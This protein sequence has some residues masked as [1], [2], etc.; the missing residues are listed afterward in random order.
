MTHD[1]QDS[2]SVWRRWDLHVHTPESKLENQFKDWA[3][4]LNKI[5]SWGRTVSVIG[6]TDYASIEGYKRLKSEIKNNKRLPDIDL[7]IPNIEFRISA[8]TKQGKGINVHLLVSPHETD[9]IERIESAL[10]KLCC[11]FGGEEYGCTRL[12]LIKLGKNVKPSIV[13]EELA[14][15]EG[16]NQFKPSI[17]EISKW[18][19][20]S[21]WLK[22]NSLVAVSNSS[23]DGV[24]GLNHD[25]G[26][27][28][29]RDEI[30]S[31]ADLV[32]SAN[33]KDREFY[34]GGG[35]LSAHQI[36]KK[37]RHLKPCVHGSDAHS[38]EKIFAPDLDRFCWIKADP[39]FEG[40]RQIIYE[41]DSRVY[42]GKQ[43][44][45]AHDQSKVIEQISISG[46]EGWFATQSIK[47]NSGLNAIIGGKGSGKTALADTIA[48]ACGAWEETS[49]SF[50]TRAKSE[51][52]NQLS[53]KIGW[54]DG[55]LVD[56]KFP[57]S[58]SIAKPLVKYLSQQF[59]E[60]LCT[61][62]LEGTELVHEIEKV[63]FSHLDEAERLG[64][65]SFTELRTLRVNSIRDHRSTLR[66]KIS[67]A[68]DRFT[69][70]EDE[71][72]QR[73]D[74]FQQRQ[75]LLGEIKTLE[76]Q[77]PPSADD[78][79]TEI[80]KLLIEARKQEESIE[81]TLA[82]FGRQLNEI[83]NVRYSFKQ[84]V[85]ASLE[86]F[87]DMESDLKAIG[88]TPAQIQLFQP[89]WSVSDV[90]SAL[91]ERESNITNSKTDL[92]GKETDVWPDN[93][94][95]T[96]I[97]SL[98]SKLDKQSNE[99]KAIKEKRRAIAISI[100]E[101]RAKT[102]KL[103]AEISRIDNEYVKRLEEVRGERK[104]LFRELFETLKKEQEILRLLY[105]PLS[106]KLA[107]SGDHEK[108]LE[109]FVKANVQFQEWADKGERLLDRTKIGAFRGKGALQEHL[110]EHFEPSLR[111]CDAEG[112]LT[113]IDALIEAMHDDQGT[114]T[115]DSQLRDKTPSRADWY[116][117]LFDTRQIGL[118]YGIRYDGVALEALS[119]GTKG[120]VLMILYLSMDQDEMA[121]LIIDQPE[122]NLD[123]ESIYSVLTPYFRLAKKRRQ[124]I[125]ITHNPNLVVNADAELIVVANHT[126]NPD[127][128]APRLRYKSGS[129]ENSR[130]KVPGCI[131]I[132]EC[133][134]DILEGGEKAF[135]ER[136]KRYSFKH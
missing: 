111:S 119:P 12:D 26:F 22:R 71:I 11:T 35:A 52:K 29:V 59:V 105:T 124:I 68:N 79:E 18:L 46:V 90:E 104:A 42:I 129:L 73:D 95:L 67:Q 101:K 7:V 91:L 24:S 27:A 60:K 13:N 123:N 37:Y 55:T 106:K 40:L 128:G 43:P 74:K 57:A 4:Y 81:I 39:T 133:V 45:A 115:L 75:S 76:D 117:W 103:E 5:E 54:A 30:Q 114:F 130:L 77:I 2:G 34:L 32:F 66:A 82:R 96:A 113:S 3:S 97:K 20:K 38:E 58:P 72:R 14:Y 132:R 48:F 16:I 15:Q 9:H 85:R 78:A 41:P 93:K 28:A 19:S 84:A 6:V 86:W 98:I 134:C 31:L 108:K 44:P 23:N 47:L 88:L 127:T 116:N 100:K 36:Q 53:V 8:E 109:F 10:Q 63:V 125:V 62:D 80:H 70:I 102:G 110:R 87:K 49:R 56:S 122:E 112:V 61:D 64:A 135:H 65:S 131:G 120:I 21:D 1:Y 118:S 89:K 25:S 92:A 94:T 126:G 83:N 69:T 99:D 121:P 50:L 17:F 51:L 33:P 136:E 107:E